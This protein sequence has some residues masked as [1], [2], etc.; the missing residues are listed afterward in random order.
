MSADCQCQPMELEVQVAIH[1][2]VFLIIVSL[3]EGGLLRWITIDL[4]HRWSPNCPLSDPDQSRPWSIIDT[5]LEVKYPPCIKQISFI[6]YRHQ[7]QIC[8][9]FTFLLALPFWYLKLQ[10][11][12]WVATQIGPGGEPS[13]G[14]AFFR[15]HGQITVVEQT[16]QWRSRTWPQ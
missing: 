11:A 7:L 15:F 4:R 16:T 1:H 5:R 3:D 2:L 13:I 10:P 14:S 6:S 8:C 9:L 12:T